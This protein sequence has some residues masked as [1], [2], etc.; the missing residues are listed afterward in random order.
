MPGSTPSFLVNIT[1]YPPGTV[2]PISNS[3]IT[4]D[5][6]GGNNGFLQGATNSPD[7]ENYPCGARYFDQK[8]YVAPTP[9]L[10][11]TGTGII[12]FIRV[13]QCGQQG[14]R[15]NK[16]IRVEYKNTHLQYFSIASASWKLVNTNPQEN[17]L[18]RL[19]NTAAPKETTAL[20]GNAPPDVFVL[21]NQDRSIRSGQ[22][23]RNL[24]GSLTNDLVGGGGP[25]ANQQIGYAFESSSDRLYLPWN[26]V[27]SILST[28][29]IRAA[30][31]GANLPN[32]QAIYIANAS[33]QI[34]ANNSDGPFQG[35]IPSRFKAI[36]D[37]WQNFYCFAG[38]PSTLA[39]PSLIPLPIYP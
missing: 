22:N 6:Q 11:Y 38:P 13:Q 35:A 9:T 27:S 26:D 25:D 1:A 30:G 18:I 32:A 21:P 29:P 5:T 19:L 31:L 17:G 34:F 3:V 10:A 8:Y 4:Y 36:N 16:N 14:R 2:P 20:P 7:P 15:P 33:I 39:S 12:P 23:A 28:T 37:Q 24:A